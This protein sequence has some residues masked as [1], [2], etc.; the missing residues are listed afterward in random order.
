MREFGASR[1]SGRLNLE[2]DNPVNTT[3]NMLWLQTWVSRA[4]FALACGESHLRWLC[5]VTRDGD[6]GSSAAEW[7]QGGR[8]EGPGELK[9]LYSVPREVINDSK[10]TQVPPA[11]QKPGPGLIIS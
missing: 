7:C 10:V 6:S 1:F 9:V 11:P 2:Q 3:P 8:T 4:G 5:G